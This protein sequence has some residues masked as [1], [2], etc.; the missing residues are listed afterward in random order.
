MGRTLTKDEFKAKE[1]DLRAQLLAV[2]RALA[3]A[4][5]PVVLVVYGVSGAGKEQVV[6]RL[7]KWFDTRGVETHAFWDETDEDLARPRYWRYWRALPPRGAI[8]IVFGGWYMEPVEQHALG[9]LSD[10][11]LDDEMN[12]AAGLEHT[13]S[14]DGALIIKLWFH[15]TGE[16]QSKRLKKRRDDATHAESAARERKLAKRRDEFLAA[17]ERAIRLTDTGKC[18]WYLIESD[19]K[20][21]RDLAVGETL[22]RAMQQRLQEHRGVD[23][24][25]QIHSPVPETAETPSITILDHVDLSEH[26]DNDDYRDQLKMLQTRLRKQAWA[27][28]E[29]KHS[30]VVVLEGWDAAGKGGAIRRLAAGIDARLYR[31]ISVAAPTDEELAHHY[32]WRFWRRVPR[33]GYVTIYDRSW[34]GRVLVERVEGFASPHEWMRAY[35]E[36]NDFE[37]QL[38]QHGIVLSKFWLQIDQGEQLQ[39]FE[40]RGRVPWKQHKITDE[41]WRNREKWDQYKQAVND[42]VEHTSTGGAPWTLVAANDKKHARIQVLK[43][44]CERL[45]QVLDSGADRQ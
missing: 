45:A 43:T 10:A 23:R 36:I 13:L 37:E 12:R 35:Q 18:P 42:M 30:T 9:E 28:Y 39:R 1:S 38:T 26:L 41:D 44:V 24:R 19:N 17:A 3:E 16:T 40:E 8:A 22:V 34:Y 2:Q 7:N 5:V 29:K 11:Q 4:T 25:A 31:S 32:L 27:A 33:A 15:L 6:D 14:Q 20:Y 21:Y